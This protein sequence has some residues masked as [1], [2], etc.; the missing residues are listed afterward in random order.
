VWYRLSIRTQLVLLM[1]LLVGII[2]FTTIVIVHNFHTEDSRKNA[3]EET[4]ILIKSLNNDLLKSILY[5][6]VSNFSDMSYRLSSYKDLQGLI[7]YDKD[8][9]PIY[10]YKDISK[11][12]KQK[13]KFKK[14]KI[15]FGESNL[16]VKSHI[17]ANNHIFGYVIANIDLTS[18]QD[19]FTKRMY[20]IL[21]MFPFAIL[22][23]FFIS[24]YISRLFTDP[25]Q[26]L[27]QAIYLS[28]PINNKIKILNT[29]SKN[30][31][32]TLF[33]GFNKFMMQISDTSNK[34]L[35]Q[36][37]YDQLTGL[38]SRFYIEQE[39]KDT[40]K[41]TS[42]TSNTLVLIGIEKLEFLQNAA[43]NEV[44]DEFSKIVANNLRSIFPKDSI[45]AKIQNNTFYILLKNKTADEAIRLIN[46][47]IDLIKNTYIAWG[48][49]YLSVK[50]KIALVNYK[51][52][53]YTFKELIKAAND[54]LHS[55]KLSSLDSIYVC[56][57]KNDI[58]EKIKIELEVANNIHDALKNGLSSFELYAQKIAS[59]Q[60][61]DNYYSYEILLRMRDKK[62]KL[63]FPDKF[64]PVAEKHQLMVQID[65]F[66]L[67]KYLQSA[68]ENPKH[69]KSLDSVHINI[70]GSSISNFEFQN[71]LRN[72]VK[73]FD[74]PWNK[75]ELELTETSS[76]GNF[77]EAQKFIKWLKEQGIGLTLDDFGTGMSSFEYLKNLPFDIVKIDGS[78]I[79]DMHKNPADKAIIK[80]IQE[81]TMLNGQKTVAEYIETQQ[82]IDELTKIG[83]TYGQG[84][85]LG[86]PKPLLEWL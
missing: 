84:Y 85:F 8:L 39:I 14:E 28:D 13:D 78:F 68:Q 80:Y 19:A 73:Q 52:L 82:D 11:I 65:I 29:K 4:Q 49:E 33:D 7:L 51:P 17:K 9:K 21:A 42:N 18:Y 61:R 24:L 64:L 58:S 67:N 56:H 23:S 70:T 75:L 47:H 32:K 81:I 71:A 31:I 35:N 74:F 22:M 76:I 77:H 79:K 48:K 5:Q 25:I 15:D 43:G 37:R 45:I 40:I 57:I 20:Y 6:S 16:I 86:K 12:N 54:T 63:I 1:I 38:Y 60:D 26:K 55:A 69:I 59:L 3:L 72:M 41:N 53:E 30:E 66:V 2:E 10:K 44:L 62:N 46:I 50:S 34:L 36:A 27:T 83:I